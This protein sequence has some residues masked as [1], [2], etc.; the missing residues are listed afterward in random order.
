[1][2]GKITK[3]YISERNNFPED[4]WLMIVWTSGQPHHHSFAATGPTREDVEM[5]LEKWRQKNKI[6]I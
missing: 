3:V 1:M 4:R 5:K 2:S 6:E